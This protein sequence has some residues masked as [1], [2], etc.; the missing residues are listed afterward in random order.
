[1]D[2]LHNAKDRFPNLKIAYLSSRIYAGY[3]LNPLNPEPHAYETAF[4]V[5]WLI[6]DQIAGMP[7]LNYDPCRGQVRCPW[8]AWGP[9]LWADGVKGRKDGLVW[10]RDDLGEDGTHPAM[11][12]RE[13]VANLL[14]DFL[15]KDPT[16]RPWFFSP[17]PERNESKPR[18]NA[19]EHR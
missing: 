16:S 9:Y 13:K 15:K 5:K 18:I 8:V 19:D 2:T 6:A 7:E 4:A 17:L 1:M 14:L 12:G 10:L 11:S 3:A